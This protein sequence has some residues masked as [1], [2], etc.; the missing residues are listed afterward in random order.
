MVL[1]CNVLAFVAVEEVQVFGGKFAGAALVNNLVYNCDRRF[2]QDAYARDDDFVIVGVVLEREECFVFPS[3]QNIALAVF[4]ECR[5]RAASARS[6][7]EHVLVELLHEFLDLGFVA[8][9]LLFGPCPSGEIV[10]ACASGSFRV[11]RDDSDAVFD[12][13][14]PVLEILRV[15]LANEEDDG[16]CVRSAVQ[17][18]F[19]D[20]AIFDKACIAHSVHVKF[21]G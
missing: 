13:V 19:L 7:Y 10:P 12:E 6:E 21:E 18:K 5:R 3:E 2:C 8:V 11:R 16:G 4:D 14:A 9:V 15:T 17:R 20:P 1:S